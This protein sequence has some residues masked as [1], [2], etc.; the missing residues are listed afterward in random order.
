MSLIYGTKEYRRKY[1]TVFLMYLISG[2]ICSWYRNH[3]KPDIFL[4][5]TIC[6]YTFLLIFILSIFKSKILWSVY[7]SVIV[8]ILDS[9]FQ[10]IGCILIDLFM[11]NFDR[12]TVL[13]ISSLIFNIAAL[14]LLRALQKSHKNQII[15]SIKLLPNEYTL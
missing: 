5:A 2:I 3:D 6:Y 1:V 8:L 7:I 11:Q 14:I 15:N 13:N 9:I 10:S 4:T 12:I